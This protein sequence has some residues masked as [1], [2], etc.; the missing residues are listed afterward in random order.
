MPS[1]AWLVVSTPEAG[2]RTTRDGQFVVGE[3]DQVPTVAEDQQAGAVPTWV[4]DPA[5]QVGSRRAAAVVSRSVID[6]DAQDV[7][8]STATLGA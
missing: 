1:G 6:P 5:D 8:D 3:S 4:D 7:T 2:V